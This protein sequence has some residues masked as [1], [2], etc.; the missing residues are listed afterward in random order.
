MG[1]LCGGSH[2]QIGVEQL[3]VVRTCGVPGVRLADR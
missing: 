1:R 2:L 3:T